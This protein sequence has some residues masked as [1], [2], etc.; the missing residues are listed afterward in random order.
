MKYSKLY[1]P[2]L[3]ASSPDA[4]ITWF[5][6]FLSVWN[7]L[8]ELLKFGKKEALQNLNLLS[9]LLGGEDENL[10][11]FPTIQLLATEIPLSAA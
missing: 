11:M 5:R 8:F 4:L 9:K 7:P 1:L 6:D 10:L 3:V 2:S